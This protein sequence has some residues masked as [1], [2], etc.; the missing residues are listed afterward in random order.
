M[1]VFFLFFFNS[2][3]VSSGGHGVTRN[4]KILILLEVNRFF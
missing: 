3:C 1:S 2:V 4:I